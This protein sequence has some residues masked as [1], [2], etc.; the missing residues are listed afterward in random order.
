MLFWT[1]TPRIFAGEAK[2]SG[3][4]TRKKKKKSEKEVGAYERLINGFALVQP[5]LYQEPVHATLH[6]LTMWWMGAHRST[7]NVSHA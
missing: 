5:G 3:G 1:H 7:P 2:Q 4:E 6:M